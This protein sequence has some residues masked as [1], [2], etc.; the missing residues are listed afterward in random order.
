[1]Y[2][3]RTRRH[4]APWRTEWGYAGKSRNLDLRDRCHRGTCTS[5]RGC[6]E[7]PWFDLVTRR[8]TIGLP[9]WLGWDWITLSME[10][11]VI[12]L[13][14]P[15][16]N[17]QKNPSRHKVRPREQAIQRSVRRAS[18]ATYRARVML[19]Q[20]VSVAISVAAVGMILIGVG[21]YLWTR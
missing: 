15:R 12:W 17:I 4:L 5:H 3:Y 6:A 16:Y 11:L 7:K 8:Y 20:A 13:L 14:R 19:G 2:V 18:P 1:M 21:G 10:T 9:W